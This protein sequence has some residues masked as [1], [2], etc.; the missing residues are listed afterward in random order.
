[1]IKISDVYRIKMYPEEGIKPKG[2]D[3]YRNKYI[4]V[5]GHDNNNTL[6]G[7]VVTNTKDHHLIP[8]DFQYPLI[9]DGYKCFVNCH[10]LYE[11]SPERLTQDCYRGNISEEHYKFIVGC[12]RTSPIIPRKK[13]KKFNLL[14]LNF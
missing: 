10:K 13:L 8:M 9:L 14:D 5:V 3:L 6:Y 11:V 12:I 4:I 7:V 2:E 1:M